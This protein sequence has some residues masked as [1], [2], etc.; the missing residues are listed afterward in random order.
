VLTNQ[1][2]CDST[3][4]TTTSLLPGDTTLLFS[5]SCNPADTGTVAQVLTNQFGCDSTVIS[6]TSLLPRNTTVFFSQ[7]CNPADTGT[8][9][10]ILTNQFGCDSIVTTQVL[11]FSDPDY[12]LVTDTL[13]AGESL[14]INGTVYDQER[15]IGQE[16]IQSIAEGCDSVVIDIALV[17]AAPEAEISLTNPA[18][19]GLTGLIEIGPPENGFPPYTITTAGQLL[20]DVSAFPVTID[21]LAGDYSVE[22]TDVLGCTTSQSVSIA[23]GISPELSIDGPLTLEQGD[24]ITLRPLLNFDPEL[25][26]WRPAGQ[27]SCSN[28]LNP[29]LEASESTTLLLTASLGNGCSATANVQVIV[30]RM[31]D[32]YAPNIFSP[33]GDGRNDWFTLFSAPGQIDRIER[34]EIYDR[35]GN[36]VFTQTDF[37]PNNT[38]VGW[39]GTFRGA[40]MG[41]GVFTYYAQV[42]LSTGS[43]ILQKGDVTLIR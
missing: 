21:V 27:L 23:E 8:V 18:C 17:F 26:D 19:E 28:C 32:I 14:V 20:E 37:P 6:T 10:Q 25:L 31:V 30:E 11:L 3:V 2:G 1:F 22:L 29:V 35:W 4:I 12:Q 40:P 5:E 16:V 43:T 39:D 33:N 9:T 7:S 36:Q 15:P 24:T 13:C 41:S 38:A 42:R 34:M